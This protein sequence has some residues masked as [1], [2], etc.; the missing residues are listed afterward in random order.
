[1]KHD[2]NAAAGVLRRLEQ[3]HADELAALESANLDDLIRCM[4]GYSSGKPS[5]DDVIVRLRR[6]EHDV[7][8]DIRHSFGIWDNTGLSGVLSLSNV[9]RGPLNCATVGFW[10]DRERRGKGLATHALSK[11]IKIAWSD[12]RLHRIEAGIISTNATSQRVLLRN[13]FEFIGLARKYLFVDG[14][15]RDHLL[16]QITSGG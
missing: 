14:E 8:A 16:F 12:L 9:I 10:I 7:E 11:A 15:W 13:G 4:P 3:K 6:L 2:E 5:P 1:M